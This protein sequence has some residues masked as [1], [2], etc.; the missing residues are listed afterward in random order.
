MFAHLADTLLPLLHA[1]GPFGLLAASLLE[2]VIAPIPSAIV[3][4]FGG[5]LLIP[6]DATFWQAALQVSYKVMLP[7]SVGMAVGSLFPY[8]IAKIGEK[9]AVDR[10]GRLLQVDWAMVEKAQRFFEEKKSDELVLFVVRAV[11]L[12]PS[13]VI[14]VFCGLIRM[15]V[16]TFL[17]FSFLGSL[18]RTFVLGMVG[19][20]V[21]A[22]YVTYAEQIKHVEDV[23]LVIVAVAAV[24]A[25]FFLWMRVRKKKAAAKAS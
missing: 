4:L 2:E 20:A 14:A 15:N 8:Y 18:I 7:A 10:F 3:V 23:G 19:W 21:G 16:W 11:P 1:Y 6:D 12:V 25:A 17:I 13:V 22:A 5:F 24:S 9:V